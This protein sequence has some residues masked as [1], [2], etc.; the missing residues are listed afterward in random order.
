MR[1]PF[2]CLPLIPL[3]GV[4]VDYH[5]TH[6]LARHSLYCDREPAVER[7]DRFKIWS[8]G[9]LRNQVTSDQPFS[10]LLLL[11]AAAVYLNQ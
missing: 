5:Q 3:S 6:F 10:Y 9:S 2:C 11:T 7:C 4:I 8:V 1:R